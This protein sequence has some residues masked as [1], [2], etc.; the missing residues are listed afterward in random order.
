MSGDDF[1]CHVH[2]GC[3]IFSADVLVEH[4]RLTGLSP[5]LLGQW[6]ATCCYSFFSNDLSDLIYLCSIF[7]FPSGRIIWFRLLDDIL[8]N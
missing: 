6:V 7:F 8:K 4:K 1:L 2:H 5:A 3:H